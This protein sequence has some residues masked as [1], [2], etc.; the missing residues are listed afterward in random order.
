MKLT[1]KEA[2]TLID[3]AKIS[4]V[5]DYPNA[6][7]AQVRTG[8]EKLRTKLESE[9]EPTLTPD[10]VHIAHHWATAAAPGYHPNSQGETPDELL[11]QKLLAEVIG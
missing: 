6:D 7:V 3:W 2:T 11:H 10:E 4:R 1:N 8:A 5:G 9:S